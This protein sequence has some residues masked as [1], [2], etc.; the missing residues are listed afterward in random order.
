[1]EDFVFLARNFPIQLQPGVH[2]MDGKKFHVGIAGQILRAPI[3]KKNKDPSK[4][5]TCKKKQ[6]PQSN[7]NLG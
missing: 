4:I 2:Y 3:E 6:G 5:V 1:M 7:R